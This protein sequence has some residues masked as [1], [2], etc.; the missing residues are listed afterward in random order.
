MTHRGGTEAETAA[1]SQPPVG[2]PSAVYVTDT[3]ADVRMIE[4]LAARYRLTLLAPSALEGRITTWWPPRLP[5]DAHTVLLPGGRKGFVVGAARWLARRRDF[6]VAFVLDNL[7]AAL[8]ATLARR[9]GGPPVVL[10]VGRP[11]AEYFSCKAIEGG[12]GW[13]H[14]LGLAL[15]KSLVAFNERLADGIGTVSDYVA[16]QC[17]KHNRMVRSIAFYGVNT[18]VFAPRWSKEEVRLA[19][20]LPA[21]DPIVLYRSRIAPEKDPDTF[22]LAVNRLRRDGRRITALYMGGEFPTFM[23]RADRLGVKVECRDASSREEL[24]MWYFAANVTVQTS[25]AEGLG[26]SLLESLACEVPIVVSDVGGLPEVARG[27]EAGI[28]VPPRDVE[29]TAAAIA[30]LLDDPGLAADLASRGR[31]WVIE[32]YATQATFDAWVELAEAVAR[33]AR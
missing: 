32:R 8:A 9:L 5:E 19:L 11:T 15:V 29:A 23:R 4:G 26:I 13:R 33:P 22:L 16:D 24:P 18:E 25:Y 28:L 14:Q 7:S 30:K 1:E 27:G 17:R 3:M 10:Q 31:A 6:D 21:G 20:G 2:R 12:G